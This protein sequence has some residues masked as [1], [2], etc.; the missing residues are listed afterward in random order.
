MHYFT[1]LWDTTMNGSTKILASNKK[2]TQNAVKK[3]Y[4]LGLGQAEMGMEA[5]PW[6]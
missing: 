2:Q 1:H 6:P 4:S 5:L 3:Q